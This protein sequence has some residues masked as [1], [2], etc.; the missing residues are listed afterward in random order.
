MHLVI[1]VSENDDDDDD[2]DNASMNAQHDASERR[3]T[4][5]SEMSAE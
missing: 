3:I 1:T 4:T 5:L 2:N